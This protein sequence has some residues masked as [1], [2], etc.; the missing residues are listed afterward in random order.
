[1]EAPEALGEALAYVE[2]EAPEVS[3]SVSCLPKR[4]APPL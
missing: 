2:A 4:P 1:M 3:F